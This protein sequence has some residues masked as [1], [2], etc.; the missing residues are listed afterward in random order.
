MRKTAVRKWEHSTLTYLLSHAGRV[1][2]IIYSA[3][4]VVACTCCHSAI[5]LHSQ[6]MVKLSI[7]SLGNERSYSPFSLHAP[8]INYMY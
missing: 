4:P 1:T 5:Q 7:T 2:R 6:D 3:E 8:G